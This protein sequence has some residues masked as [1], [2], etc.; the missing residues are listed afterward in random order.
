MSAEYHQAGYNAD[1]RKIVWSSSQLLHW[2]RP[3]DYHHPRLAHKLY[4]EGEYDSGPL[5][6]D[7]L[8]GTFLDLM[9]LDG[10]RLEPLPA[11]EVEMDLGK[12][13]KRAFASTQGAQRLG[14]LYLPPKTGSGTT[15]QAKNI[16]TLSK[17]HAEERGLEWTAP[18]S[19]HGLPSVTSTWTALEQA[20][21]IVTYL[22]A[23]SEILLTLPATARKCNYYLKVAEG[24]NH[25]VYEAS[26]QD[27]PL[28]TELDRLLTFESMKWAAPDVP[29]IV[30]LKRIRFAAPH[31]FWRWFGESGERM[32]FAFREYVYCS[33][34]GRPEEEI[35][36]PL[37]SLP[38]IIC[39]TCPKPTP[40]AFC[41]VIDETTENG[42]Q[43]QE[44]GRLEFNLTMERLQQTLETGVWATPEEQLDVQPV[45]PPYHG[46]W[47]DVENTEP[48]TEDE[49][50]DNPF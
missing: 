36:Q 49:D 1:P 26:W 15:N 17:V 27:V 5:S 11:A 13:G 23:D 7:A 20:L 33:R 34:N 22:E 28:R 40:Q 44:L 4:V 29:S 6:K 10:A 9:L 32:R 45:E 30:D 37:S 25:P 41:Y 16:R 19:D 14:D 18:L 12:T 3:D 35:E 48:I 21:D 39:A 46:H 8:S 24:V 50:D 47:R 31:R 38:W 43:Q 42:R 2:L